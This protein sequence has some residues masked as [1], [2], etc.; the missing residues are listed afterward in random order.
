MEIFF[1]SFVFQT[2]NFGPLFDG[3]IVD[4]LILPELVRATA[5]NASRARRTTL[6]NH[7]ELYDSIISF[8]ISDYLE[9]CFSFSVT[10]NV[11]VYWIRLFVHIKK[12]QPMKNFL[13]NRSHLWRPRHCVSNSMIQERKVSLFI[14]WITNI[15]QFV[16]ILSWIWRWERRKGNHLNIYL[17]IYW[18]FI[19]TQLML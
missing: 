14:K 2:T 17:C 13:P 19:L 6:N 16:V 5:I 12:K 7:C 8:S 18:H 9:F 4:K 15:F 10:K 3:A 1:S 11:I